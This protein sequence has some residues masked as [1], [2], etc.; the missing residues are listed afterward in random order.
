MSAARPFA[1]SFAVTPR[2]DV[3]YAL[4]ALANAAPSP[5]D[6][7]KE[8]AIARLPE[9]FGRVA[10]RVAPV[11]LFWPLLADALQQTSGEMAFDEIVDAIRALPA[12]ELTTNIVSGIFHDSGT[13]RS[14]VSGHKKLRDVVS[15]DGSESG[16]L[17]RAFG[18]RPFD[19]MSRSAKA[20]SALLL[21]PDAFRED[22]ALVLEQFWS[23]T[24]RDDWSGLEAPLRADSFR[25]RDLAEER[26]IED[27]ARELEL[28][29]VFDRKASE[30]RPRSGPAIPYGRIDTCCLI[31]SAF[32]TRHWWAK[33]ETKSGRV[34]LYFPITR[35]ASAANRRATDAARSSAPG[36]HARPKV[37]A[38]SVFR[39]LG[40]TTRYA[41]ASVLAR[42]P[43]TSAEL[44]RMLGVSKPTITHHV[45]ALRSAGLIAETPKG[46]SVRL[47]LNR[48]TVGAISEAAV[49]QLFASKADLSLGTTRKRRA[50]QDAGKEI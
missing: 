31:P 13:V 40:D 15:Q 32:N 17:L 11:P 41:I 28:P 42:T 27:L 25:M 30:V 50:G 22:L 26:A 46:G 38:E 14:L 8:R 34:S 20:I 7:W 29:V 10:G 24:F 45:Q 35:D 48:E 49:G 6:E 33:Y 4:Y 44:A 47:S 21:H 37:D 9:D 19:S 18:L 1:V 23:T 16:E 2:F 5:S 3:F 12:E 39:A 36:A 43:T